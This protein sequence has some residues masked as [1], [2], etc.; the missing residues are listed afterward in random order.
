MISS[1]VRFWQNKLVN[2]CPGRLPAIFL[3]RK[4][5]MKWWVGTIYPVATADYSTVLYVEITIW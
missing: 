3:V 2:N 5:H 1:K 4:K